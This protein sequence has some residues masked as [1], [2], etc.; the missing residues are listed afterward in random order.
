MR[1]C[2][3]TVVI[4]EKDAHGVLFYS[5]DEHEKEV[6]INDFVLNDGNDLIDIIMPDLEKAAIADMSI[7]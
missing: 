6:L 5:Y 3:L 1:K 2:D 7:E 4:N